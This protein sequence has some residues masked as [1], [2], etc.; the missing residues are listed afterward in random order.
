MKPVFEVIQHLLDN[1]DQVRQ[2]TLDKHEISIKLGVYT[3]TEPL[4]TI[5]TQIED[6]R[7]L[8]K[9]EKIH[10]QIDS[11]PKYI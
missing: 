7:M 6:I 10:N 8:S 5:F 11:Y 4:S 2:K 3:L 9:A 1:Y